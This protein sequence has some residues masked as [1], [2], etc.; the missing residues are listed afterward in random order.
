[1]NL[2]NVTVNITE[3]SK[4]MYFALG[5]VECELKRVEVIPVITSA[6]DGKHGNNSLHYKNQAVDIRIHDIPVIKR[7]IIRANIHRVLNPRG[8]DVLREYIG[9]PNEHYHIEFDPKGDE[10]IFVK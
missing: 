7:E 9:T 2:K 4:E 3:L 8:F 1:M 10:A 6:N 5:V